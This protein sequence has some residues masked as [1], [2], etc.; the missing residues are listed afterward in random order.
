MVFG[1]DSADFV[2]IYAEYPKYKSIEVTDEGMACIDDVAW[3]AV[4]YLCF[5]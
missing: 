4:S 1:E 3:A 2:F 5:Y